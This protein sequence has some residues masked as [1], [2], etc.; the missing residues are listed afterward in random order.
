ML[1]RRFVTARHHDNPEIYGLKPLWLN[2]SDPLDGIGCAHDMLEHAPSDSG[3]GDGEFMALG[4][5]WRIRGAN[6]WFLSKHKM[7]A[8]KVYGNLVAGVLLEIA[9]DN[10]IPGEP[11]STRPLDE[12][13][14]DSID[15]IVR[16]AIQILA[17][18]S[19]TD[20]IALPDSEIHTR[21]SGFLRRGM[22]LA[23]RRYGPGNLE[24]VENA[25]NAIGR[26]VDAVL[27]RF[28]GIG[29]PEGLE[30]AVSADITMGRAF[31]RVIGPDKAVAALPF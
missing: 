4:A 6:G 14:E 16:E 28:A 23:N 15:T 7:N 10:R 12:C 11:G 8:E 9:S 3:G 30:I 22:R 21:V 5:S 29:H 17:A 19:E 18:N 26:E 31:V 13:D 2:P 1:T 20:P 24:A 27:T 25:F